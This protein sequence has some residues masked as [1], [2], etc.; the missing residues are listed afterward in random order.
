VVGDPR[1]T[2]SSHPYL[3][4]TDRLASA[5]FDFLLL[6]GRVML[7][8]IFL[9]S[10]WSKLMTYSGFTGRMTGQGVPSFLAYI[11]PIIEFL[12][13][14]GLVLGLATRYSAL[15]II[16]FTVAATWIAH[17]YWT[18]T[19]PARGQNMTQFWKNISILGGLLALFAAGPGRISIDRLLGRGKV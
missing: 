14:A 12:G 18:M 3:S 17:R 5:W 11:A 19:E 9:Q 1:A 8:W 7:G 2:T 13:G 4:Y 6:L 16:A 15:L 10:G